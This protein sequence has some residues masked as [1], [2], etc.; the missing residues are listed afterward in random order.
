LGASTL[1]QSKRLTKVKDRLKK[2]HREISKFVNKMAEVHG[3]RTHLRK[4][5]VM[6]SQ[7]LIGSE[8]VKVKERL[9]ES[10]NTVVHRDVTIGVSLLLMLQ[11]QRVKKTMI[12]EIINKINIDMQLIP[13]F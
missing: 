13:P 1:R 9:K 10:Y 3:N 12:E 2:Y 7:Y 6:S 4:I 11:R 8:K 5:I